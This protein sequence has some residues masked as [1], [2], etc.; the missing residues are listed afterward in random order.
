MCVFCLKIFL[1]IF[2][3]RGWRSSFCLLFTKNLHFC[4]PIV[5]V[6][7]LFIFSEAVLSFLA[8]TTVI[9]YDVVLNVAGIRYSIFCAIALI[10]RWHRNL[11]SKITTV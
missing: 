1:F 3:T 5:H 8:V 11:K 10:D 4:Y 6:W 2:S 7:L 9:N